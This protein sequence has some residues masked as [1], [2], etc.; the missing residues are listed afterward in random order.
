VPLWFLRLL[1]VVL[2]LGIVAGLFL[3]AFAKAGLL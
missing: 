2:A 3:L 1:G